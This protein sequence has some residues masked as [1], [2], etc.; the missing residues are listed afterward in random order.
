MQHILLNAAPLNCVYA[1]GHGGG[2]N[3]LRTAVC[4]LYV[5]DV[6]KSSLRTVTVL[7]KTTSSIYGIIC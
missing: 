4:A 1:L 5:Q 2:R 6:V 7:I 3:A